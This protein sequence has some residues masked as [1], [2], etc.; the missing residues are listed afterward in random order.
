MS[1][2]RIVVI[3]SGLICIGLIGIAVYLTMNGSTNA[4]RIIAID[5]SYNKRLKD[6]GWVRGSE[7]PEVTVLEY[8][9]FQC[10]GCATYAP[11][12]DEA[13]R[14]TKDYV[15]FIYRQYPL[16]SHNKAKMAAEAAESAGRQGKFWD[17]YT[18]IYANQNNWSAKTTT[19]F[20]TDLKEFAKSIGLQMDQF[21]NDMNDSSIDSAINSDIALGNNL[22]VQATP[23]I[24][25]NDKVLTE[26][27]KDAASFIALLEQ[28]RVKPT[29]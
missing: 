19:E 11:V 14:A 26:F 8:A 20:K 7:N 28:S 9:D 25:V 21:N 15:K 22:P 27:P 24:I 10:P 12:I 17:M 16:P 4:A 5:E 13:Y 2:N 29:P 18:V 1:P 3:V 23:T 6:Q